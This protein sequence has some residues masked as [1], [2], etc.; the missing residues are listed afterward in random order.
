MNSTDRHSS[1]RIKYTLSFLCQVIFIFARNWRREQSQIEIVLFEDHLICLLA[2]FKCG[3]IETSCHLIYLDLLWD[4]SLWTS[5]LSW[6]QWILI[7]RVKKSFL[8]ESKN[9]YYQA[10]YFTH[11]YYLNAMNKTCTK[12]ISTF[13]KKEKVKRKSLQLR[14]LQTLANC[15][16]NFARTNDVWWKKKKRVSLVEMETLYDLEPNTCRRKNENDV[17]A[18]VEL[19]IKIPLFGTMLPRISCALLLLK[20]KKHTRVTKIR[21]QK[22][23]SK[24]EG[25]PA[26]L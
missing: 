23:H 14:L 7:H 21:Q 24:L 1:F 19:R 3:L 25:E 10:C 17:S 16:N 4:S 9:K 26:E 11:I 2:K 5:H 8:S 20:E 6:F 22:G 18:I 12:S 15:V 13:E